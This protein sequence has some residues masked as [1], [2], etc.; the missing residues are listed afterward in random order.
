MDWATQDSQTIFR[1]YL[2]NSKTF[3]EE[4]S[5]K[6]SVVYF[7]RLKLCLANVR[8]SDHDTDSSSTEPEVTST[9]GNNIS[10]P[11]TPNVGESLELVEE[12]DIRGK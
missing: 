12:D 6:Y 10:P 7:D 9:S 2:Q 3:K 1:G 4:D 11:C 5:I 8:L